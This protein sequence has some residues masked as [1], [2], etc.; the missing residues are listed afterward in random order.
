[1]SIV[2]S[3][4]KVPEFEFPPYL[5]MAANKNFENSKAQNG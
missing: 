5:K 1:M 3:R 2:A 4:L